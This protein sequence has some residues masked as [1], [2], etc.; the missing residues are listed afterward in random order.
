[1]RM[2]LPYDSD[3]GRAIAG[4]VTAILTGESYAASAEMAARAWRR[5]PSY[6]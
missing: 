4:A 3:E 6:P 2:G 1:M 5:S